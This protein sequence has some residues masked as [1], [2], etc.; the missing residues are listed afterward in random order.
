MSNFEELNLEE[1]FQVVGGAFNG[2][3][4]HLSECSS[5]EEPPRYSDDPIE[6]D[7]LFD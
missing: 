2:N 3:N 6:E 4:N 1:L 7:I 5:Q